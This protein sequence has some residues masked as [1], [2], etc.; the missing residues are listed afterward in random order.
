MSPANRNWSKLSELAEII[1]TGAAMVAVDFTNAIE[2]VGLV[3][4]LT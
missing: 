1:A 2:L 4:A 3:A